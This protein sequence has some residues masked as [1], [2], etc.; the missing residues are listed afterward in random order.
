MYATCVH[1]PVASRAA[2]LFLRAAPGVNRSSFPHPNSSPSGPRNRVYAGNCGEKWR[3]F[4][5]GAHA[6]TQTW[7]MGRENTYGRVTTDRYGYSEGIP[8]ASKPAAAGGA[9]DDECWRQGG[10]NKQLGDEQ[11]EDLSDNKVEQRMAKRDR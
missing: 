5:A 3:W 4:T 10:L 7:I 2:R 9:G 11:E 8:R 6:G 1:T